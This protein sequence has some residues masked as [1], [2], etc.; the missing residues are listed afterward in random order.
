M[1]GDVGASTR[2]ALSFIQ[3]LIVHMIDHDR[4]E[5]RLPNVDHVFDFMSLPFRVARRNR[6]LSVLSQ[7]AES[8]RGQVVQHFTIA[9]RTRMMSYLFTFREVDGGRYIRI[10]MVPHRPIRSL[11][12]LPAPSPKGSPARCTIRPPG[13]VRAGR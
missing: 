10:N 2:T 5:Y 8:R 9:S 1:A 4:H 6:F 11:E 3:E 12:D 7:Y 13:S